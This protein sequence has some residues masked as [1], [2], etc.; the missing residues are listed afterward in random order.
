[1][2]LYQHREEYYGECVRKIYMPGITPKMINFDY[3]KQQDFHLM[4]TL[5]VR[6]R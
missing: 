4:T 2:A 1:M 6:A 3:S 5:A